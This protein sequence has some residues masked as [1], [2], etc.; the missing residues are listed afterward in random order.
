MKPKT[1]EI[2][3]K[4]LIVVCCIVFVFSLYKYL[5]PKINLKK[6]SD[7]QDELVNEVVDS[8]EDDNS[9]LYTGEYAHIKVDFDALLATNE[10]VIGWLYIPKMETDNDS[11][12]SYPLMHTED[13]HDYLVSD[14][15]GDYSEAG[16]PFVDMRSNDDLSDFN[17]V[18]YGHYTVTRYMFGVMYDYMFEDSYQDCPYIYIYRPDNTVYVYQFYSA[19]EVVIADTTVFYMGDLTEEQKQAVVDETLSDSRFDFG[20]DVTTEDHIITLI[21]C[22]MGVEEARRLAVHAVLTEVIDLS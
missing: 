8:D 4:I 15:N 6:A 7:K 21:C 12:F 14:W 20:V 11:G 9:D 13:N 22:T 2:I 1:K 3:R 17:T 10:D 16:L 5:E 18:I 19:H